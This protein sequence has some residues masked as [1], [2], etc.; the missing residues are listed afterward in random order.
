MKAWPLF[1][2]DVVPELPGVPYPLVDQWLRNT[3]IEF[4]ERSKVYAVDLDPESAV[5]NEGEY[6]LSLP[7]NTDLVEIRTVLFNGVPITPKTP[8]F[9]EEKYG[10]W[11]SKTGTPD[12]VTQRD[13]E[14]YLL[15]PAP[16]AAAT[17][18]IKVKVAIKPGAAAAGVENWIF[19][20]WRLALAAG[21]KSRMMLMGDVPWSNPNLAAV[22]L[23]TFEDA[24]HKA[25]NQASNG[26]VRARPRF[27]GSFC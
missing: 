11:L 12:H 18:A 5:A 9:L 15:V 4:C 3:T 22:H 26:F 24:V 25:T 17:D 14:N 20:Q 2:S 27:S 8:Q 6:T 23:A 16:S 7:T 13:T 10:D 1:Y 21:A 19:S